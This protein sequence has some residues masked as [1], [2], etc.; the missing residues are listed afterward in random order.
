MIYKILSQSC[1]PEHARL[2]I[3]TEI[4]AIKQILKRGVTFDDIP[5]INHLTN[6]LLTQTTAH[7]HFKILKYV[8][9]LIFFYR[10]SKLID[11]LDIA[12]FS[13]LL[14]N[15]KLAITMTSKPKR[16]GKGSF[17]KVEQITVKTPESETKHIAVK[18][19]RLTTALCVISAKQEIHIL[20][21]LSSNKQLKNPHSLYFFNS[22]GAKIVSQTTKT[23]MFAMYLEKGLKHDISLLTTD[24]DKFNVMSS[25]ANALHY[26]QTNFQYSISHN[27][28]KSQQIMMGLDGRIKLI[29]FG[30]SFYFNTKTKES[31]FSQLGISEEQIGG[32]NPPPDISEQRYYL[33]KGYTDL[34]IKYLDKIDIWAYGGLLT[35]L[36]AGDRLDSQYV[37]FTK[38]QSRGSCANFASY[39]KQNNKQMLIQWSEYIKAKLNTL[40]LKPSISSLIQGCLEPDPEKRLSINEVLDSLKTIQLVLNT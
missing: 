24:A 10:S 12:I 18:T 17:G 35:K 30:M 14:Q 34:N 31:L 11:H 20:N 3:P 6:S 7:S 21:L 15:Q 38:E 13:T 8:I 40:G 25:I 4:K 16:I 22:Y 37:F 26:L 36:W 39:V 5:Q 27:D 23:I 32:T 9:T 28:L 19:I 1:I 33:L 29:D 2:F